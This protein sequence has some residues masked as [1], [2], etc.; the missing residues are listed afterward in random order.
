M[1]RPSG[2]RTVLVPHAT[3]TL[4]PTPPVTQLV[5]IALV[6][7]V[8]QLVDGSLGMA[9]GVTSTTL[10]LA[11]G[12]SPAVASASV[13]F[14]EVGTTAASGLSHLRFGNVDWPTVRRIALPGGI[15]AFLGAT[16]LVNVSA[17]AAKPIIAVFLLVLGLYVVYRFSVLALNGRR[18]PAWSRKRL[19]VLGLV[20]GFLDAAGGG[21]WGPIATPTLL[22]SDTLPPNKVV[23]SV[24]ASEF[25]VALAASL[26]FLIGLGHAEIAWPIVAAL[27]ISGVAAAPLAAWL[28]KIVPPR[29]LGVGAGGLIVLTNSRTL[30]QAAGVGERPMAI[31]YLGLVATWTVALVWTI[32]RVRREREV[33]A[34][35][36]NAHG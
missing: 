20:A 11:V 15:G 31:A 26:G 9:Y 17:A 18:R 7:F 21:G 5:L 35:T 10:L 23:G 6:G 32:L 14:S 19:G 1:F 12:L 13:H 16:V 30:M 24:D 8:A 25:V 36:V 28:V 4:Y 22:V 27:L 3:P 2:H 33:V 34:E 29:L